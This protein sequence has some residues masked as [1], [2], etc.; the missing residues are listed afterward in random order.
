MKKAKIIFIISIVLFTVSWIRVFWQTLTKVPPAQNMTY[1]T[2]N[3][4][5]WLDKG[6]PHTR[7]P[8]I[9][10]GNSVWIY[11]MYE[12]DTGG[13][14]SGFIRFDL[15]SGIAQMRWQFPG[16]S[17][18]GSILGVAKHKNGEIAVLWNEHMGKV[19]VD[20]MLLRGGLKSLGFVPVKKPNMSFIGFDWVN[21]RIEVAQ[22]DYKQRSTYIY[23]NTKKDS[24]SERSISWAGQYNFRTMPTLAMY[25]KRKWET[26][27]TQWELKKRN[28]FYTAAV[29]KYRQGD[30]ASE[31]IGI[32][33]IKS[34]NVHHLVDGAPGNMI[35]GLHYTKQNFQLKDGK[36]VKIKPGTIASKLKKVH[37]DTYKSTFIIR[38]GHLERQFMWKS[39]YGRN[40]VIQ[41]GVREIKLM[42]KRSSKAR[43]VRRALFLS[44]GGKPVVGPVVESFRFR[45]S[46]PVLI[47]AGDGGVWI[48]GTFGYYVKVDKNLQRTDAPCFFGRYA[49]VIASFGSRAAQ[50]DD[51]YLDASL[52]KKL[53]MPVLHF[54]LP[55]LWLIIYVLGFFK[56]KNKEDKKVDLFERMRNVSIA[57]IVIWVGYAYW[58]WKVTINF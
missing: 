9:I 32:V 41:L 16:K 12:K 22:G 1:Q 14:K 56:G 4:A 10:D 28:E 52:F 29:F 25:N 31:K 40:L 43:N 48:L 47:P 55:L 11:A 13:K 26:I 45:G 30:R 18:Y 37:L 17:R 38:P 39:E 15:K 58:F 2:G 35:S 33:K 50:Y 7:Y 34:Y 19:R 54:L 27:F 5:K 23:R 44:D 3:G 57:Y 49:R 6:Y 46:Y 42:F 53:V 20:I 21:G 8:R 51:F 24:W 36:I